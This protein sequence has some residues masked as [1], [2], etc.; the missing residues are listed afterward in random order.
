MLQ[1]VVQGV[2]I[3]K[4]YND[5]VGAEAVKKLIPA[6]VEKLEAEE[7][8]RLKVNI[9]ANEIQLIV[10]LECVVIL[11]LVLLDSIHWCSVVDPG[12]ALNCGAMRVLVDLLSHNNCDIRAQTARN[13]MDLRSENLHTFIIKLRHILIIQF[14]TGG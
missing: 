6:L 3:Y 11:Q 10:L 12:P 9:I 5:Y 14:P 7:D 2:I 13:I 4:A 8:V 1:C